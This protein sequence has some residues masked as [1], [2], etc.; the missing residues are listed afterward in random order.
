MKM[1][2]VLLLSLFSVA[3]SSKVMELGDSDFKDTLE[4]IEIALVKFYAPW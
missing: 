4:D 3:L 2:I 1:Y